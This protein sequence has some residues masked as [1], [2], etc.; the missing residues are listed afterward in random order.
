MRLPLRVLLI[1]A[2]KDDAHVIEHE[3]KRSNYELTIH[4]VEIAATLQAALDRQE[5]DI[6][7]SDYLLPEFGGLEAL[8]LVHNSGIDLPFLIVS[9]IVGEEVAVAAMVAGADDYLLKNSLARLGPT[10]ERELRKAKIRRERREAVEALRQANEELESKIAERTLAIS[11]ANQQLLMEIYERKQTEKELQAQREF[12]TKLIDNSG[13]AII[14][15]D[16]QHCVLFWNKAAEQ[17]TGVKAEDVVGTNQHW[18]AFYDHNR[19]TLG[20][21]IIDGAYD[22]LP[23]LYKVYRHSSHLSDNAVYTEDW[24]YSMNGKDRYVVFDSCPVYDQEGQ[25]MAAITTFHDFTERKQAEEEVNRALEKERELGELKSRFVSIASHEFRTP[26]STILSSTELLDHYGQHWSE[27]KR[28]VHL[29]RIEVAVKNMTLLLNDVL[30]IGKVEA[31]KLQFHPTP[32]NLEIFCRELVEEL[33]LS[34]GITGAINF[35]AHGN[36]SEA[37]LDEKLLRQIL[38]NLL[39]NAVKY[40]PESQTIYFKLCCTQTQATFQIRD[41]GIGIPLQDQPH[42]FEI[43]H[44]AENVGNIAGTGLGLSIVKSSV[45]LHGG[46]L[47][48]TSQ[49]GVGTTFSIVLPLNTP[50]PNL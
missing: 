49:V 13:V 7:I 39:S 24:F 19:P 2:S 6:V 15:L 21:I 50:K 10:I 4:R 48:F 41:R 11:L 37:N 30:T 23:E 46:K 31:G 26:L 16:L 45:E 43:F 47:S 3:L 34:S 17:L 20:D 35:E 1:E 42:I 9:D 14:V 32:L 25:L 29:G 27:E 18:R 33:E 44:R 38:N 12:T 40:S 28:K 36:C 5:W 22:R 8:K